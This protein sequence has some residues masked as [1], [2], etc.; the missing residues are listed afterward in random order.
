MKKFLTII[1]ALALV[2]SLSVPVFAA[3]PTSGKTDLSIIIETPQPTY[4]VSIPSALDLQLG[5]N[6][7]IITA[8][9]IE[10]LGGKRIAV[11]FEG[12]GN[13]ATYF[14]PSTYLALAYEEDHTTYYVDYGIS[15]NGV[16]QSSGPPYFLS[17]GHVLMYFSGNGGPDFGDEVWLYIDPNLANSVKPDVQY[18]GIIFFGIKLV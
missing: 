1:L 5:G 17:L 10:D 4:T 6:Q 13:I 18:T 12:N 11:S 16:P 14:G 3:N 8:S 7:L 9:D 15:I 2:M